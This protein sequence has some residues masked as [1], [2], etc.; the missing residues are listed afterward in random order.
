M[1]DVKLPVPTN[2]PNPGH[3]DRIGT[4][5]HLEGRFSILTQGRRIERT[6]TRRV[7]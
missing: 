2:V 5:V 4:E 6:K 7:F 1:S 3:A